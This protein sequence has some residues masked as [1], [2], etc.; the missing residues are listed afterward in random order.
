[1]QRLNIESTVGVRIL[2]EYF[3]IFLST[4]TKHYVLCSDED[5]TF[6]V[7]ETALNL[8]LRTEHTLRCNVKVK[9]TLQLI[10]LLVMKRQRKWGMPPPILYSRYCVKAIGQL[11]VPGRDAKMSVI[12]EPGWVSEPLWT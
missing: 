6:M 11:R 9:L 8:V 7:E 12:P 5:V 1:M 4:T 3:K 10:N 2:V